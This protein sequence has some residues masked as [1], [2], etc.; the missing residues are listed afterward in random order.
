MRLKITGELT[1][2]EINNKD[3]YLRELRDNCFY[4]KIDQ[5]NLNMKIDREI[6]AEEFAE[7]SFPY[8]LLTELE[9]N[10]QALHLAY[11]MLKEVQE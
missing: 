10:N 5:S 4:A 3:D 7:S 6:I 11:K 9:D 8:Q 2:T 1:R